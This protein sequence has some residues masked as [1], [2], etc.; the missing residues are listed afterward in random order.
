MRFSR[1]EGQS[2]LSQHSGCVEP[3]SVDL[4]CRTAVTPGSI[5]SRF[6]RPRAER[7]S[8]VRLSTLWEARESR[9]PRFGGCRCL[10]RSESR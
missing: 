2:V 6:E 1:Q 8:A 4:W 3:C 7:R 10:L 5:T 9:P